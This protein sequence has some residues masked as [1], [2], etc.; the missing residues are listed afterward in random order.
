MTNELFGE[1]RAVNDD[2]KPLIITIALDEWLTLTTRLTQAEELIGKL[3][4]A[5][6]DYDARASASKR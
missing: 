1:G 2:D 5:I 6:A 4:Q 3:R